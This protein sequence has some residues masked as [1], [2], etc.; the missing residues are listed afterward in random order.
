MVVAVIGFSSVALLEAGLSN[1]QLG[2]LLTLAS[3]VSAFLQIILSR[4]ADR[5][6][7]ASLRSYLIHISIALIASAPAPRWAGVAMPHASPQEST[8]RVH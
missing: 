4:R 1:S 2:L 7:G 3:I 8:R 5:S 6:R